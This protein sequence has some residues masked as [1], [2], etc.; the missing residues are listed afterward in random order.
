[1]A[2][3]PGQAEARHGW[4]WHL[5][6]GASGAVLLGIAVLPTIEIFARWIF[7]TGLA[8]SSDLTH[9][10]VLWL[11]CLGGAIT[12]RENKHITL[13]AGVDLI[14][15]PL[16]DWIG[17]LTSFISTAIAAAMTWSSL[18]LVLIGFDPSKRIGFVPVQLAAAVL[19][20]GF[21]LMTARFVGPGPGGPGLGQGPGGRAG[22]G[23][24]HH[25]GLQLGAER[26][27][28][29]VS[30]AAGFPVPPGGLPGRGLGPP[31]R[32]GDNTADRLGAVRHPDLHRPG[33][34]GLPAVRALRRR[35]GGDPQ[36]GLR[37]AHRL[38]PAGH[39][40]VHLRRLHPL[41]EPGGQA[42]G[43][44]VQ[45]L[46]GLASGRPGHHGGAGLDLLHHLHRRHRG[47]HPGP[48]LPA[49]LRAAERRLPAGLQRGAGDLLGLHRPAASRPACRSSST[50]SPPRSTSSTC[51]PGASCPGC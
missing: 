41:G 51:S 49:G 22:A 33:R 50:G 21:A 44:P 4:L 20:L 19:P 10:L 25:P 14:R 23:R 38:Q 18:S 9:H 24:G 6:N 12:S 11:T 45:G 47:D 16:R 29:A 5:E 8:S 46:R 48:G 36:R 40:P 28:R 27:V 37:H 3:E 13:S 31:G 43:A 1:M 32:A 35:P 17:G 7:R 15:Q 42:P 26:P 30:G 2:A 39:P 34:G